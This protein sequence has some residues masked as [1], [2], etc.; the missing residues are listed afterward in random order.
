MLPSA[1]SS[2]SSKSAGPSVELGL[3]PFAF[4]LKMRDGRGLVVQ[5]PTACGGETTDNG[6]V[7]PDLL[8]LLIIYDDAG[9]PTE[10]TGYASLDAYTRPNSDLRFRG[11]IISRASRAEF[12]EWR[13]REAPR[14]IVRPEMIPFTIG[15]P[16]VPSTWSPGTP[17]FG[18]EC[19]GIIRVPLPERLQEE[20]R[21]HRTNNHS[22][23]WAPSGPA[24]ASILTVASSYSQRPAVLIGAHPISTY[25]GSGFGTYG[26]PTPGEGGMIMYRTP[27]AD[28]YPVSS[29]FSLT[30]LTPDGTV[31]PEL[32]AKNRLIE[33]NAMV[34][35]DT[36]GLV[37]CFPDY[38]PTNGKAGK[39]W[40]PGL[41]VDFIVNGERVDD[42]ATSQLGHGSTSYLYFQ[43]DTHAYRGF[44]IGLTS[45]FG[46]L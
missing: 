21:Q 13:E 33:A 43:N 44:R 31:A 30:N 45:I 8:P 29:D 12:E 22:R 34:S 39:I 18:S 19:R 26:L 40:R 9:S 3:V 14:N 7:P 17:L 5:P 37:R 28:I 46:G 11:A 24:K 16:F 35:P 4:G 25:S 6:R 15:A 10:G 27:A 20:V 42:P 41:A 1:R 2:C 23:Y 36:L 32:M 38:E